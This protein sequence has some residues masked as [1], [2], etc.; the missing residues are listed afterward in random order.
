MTTKLR[1]SFVSDFD[2]KS[3]IRW[4]VFSV[5]KLFV[6]W[7]LSRLLG[8]VVSFPF[9]KSSAAVAVNAVADVVAVNGVADVV[10][11]NAVVDVDVVGFR[12]SVS[13][14]LTIFSIAITSSGTGSRS[15]PVPLKLLEKLKSVNLEKMN[16]FSNLDRTGI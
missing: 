10:V 11:V 8:I 5:I 1:G 9:N 4:S 13:I 2:G 12:D 7:D 6:F 3:P 14:F 15:F 16:K